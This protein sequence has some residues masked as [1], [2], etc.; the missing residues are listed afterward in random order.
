MARTFDVYLHT[1]LVGRLKQ[2]SDGGMSFQ[3]TK[4]WLQTVPRG[5]CRGL[6]LQCVL[7][8]RNRESQDTPRRASRFRRAR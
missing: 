7:E 1:H 3:Y 4:G 6:R 5:C 2:D 8:K